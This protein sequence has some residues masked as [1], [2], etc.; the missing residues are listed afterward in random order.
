MSTAQP[1]TKYPDM[2]ATY[3]VELPDVDSTVATEL[4]CD[5]QPGALRQRYSVEWMYFL[6]N[7]LNFYSVGN[8]F[9]ITVNVTYYSTDSI[10]Q[11]EVSIDHSGTGAKVRYSGRY[12][13]IE[14]TLLEGIIL[15]F[16]LYA[17]KIYVFF[18]KHQGQD[19]QMVP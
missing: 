15:E 3:E 6:P 4:I 7:S 16:I 2:F 5:I 19:C 10:Y 8:N 12:I 11:C 1:Q 14:S 9:N 18:Q 17:L 13:T